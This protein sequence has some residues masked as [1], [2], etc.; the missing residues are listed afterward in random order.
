MPNAER[1]EIKIPKSKIF[2][3]KLLYTGVDMFTVIEDFTD[4]SNLEL[5][6]INL[7]DLFVVVNI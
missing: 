7:K 1:V 5:L 6:S 2:I 4:L 3:G